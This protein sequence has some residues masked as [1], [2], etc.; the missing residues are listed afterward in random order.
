[1][2]STGLRWA[3]RLHGTF[4]RADLLTHWNVTLLQRLS[5]DFVMTVSVLFA[6][7]YQLTGNTLHELIGTA[8]LLLFLIHNAINWRWLAGVLKGRYNVRRLIGTSVNLLLLTDATLLMA[9]GITN[10]RFVF[11]WMGARSGLLDRSFHALTAY[12]FLVLM[13]VHL[14]LH[15]RT[16]VTQV[17]KLARGSGLDRL[18]P[19]YARVCSALIGAYGVYASSDREILS[20]LTGY[21]SFD[22]WDFDNYALLFFLE[23]AAII[24]LYVGVSHYAMR[25]IQ[26]WVGM[27]RRYARNGQAKIRSV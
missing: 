25:M 24:G 7:A 4:R 23:Y 15:W 6:F 19:I 9:S 27:P 11:E 22:Y 8:I 2:L 18:N 3:A 13:A 12:W 16:V 20:R 21:I 14:G 10:S 1:M 5:I 26:K 17:C